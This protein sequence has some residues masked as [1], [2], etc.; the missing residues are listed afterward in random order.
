MRTLLY[1]A[2]I[3][4]ISFQLCNAQFDNW[5][6]GE[7]TDPSNPNRIMK[8][9][10]KGVIWELVKGTLLK[11]F[12]N[13]TTEFSL[14]ISNLFGISLQVTSTDL[15][16]VYAIEG[17][18]TVRNNQLVKIAGFSGGYIFAFQNKFFSLSPLGV[19]ASL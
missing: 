14:P 10:S 4:L 19:M 1:T 16:Y 5:S 12:N 9:D 15:P 6:R 18:F 13:D 17:S 2:L 8:T 11:T 7:S 3:I